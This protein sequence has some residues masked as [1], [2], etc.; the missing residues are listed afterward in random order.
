MRARAGVLLAGLIVVG[1]ATS[2]GTVRRP[3]SVPFFPSPRVHV[4]LC[5]YRQPEVAE[6]RVSHDTRSELPAECTKHY[7]T[8]KYACSLTGGVSEG[9]RQHI[10][11]TGPGNVAVREQ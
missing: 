4:G 9:G 11:C 7:P 8:M 5:T 6:R 10:T 1:C 3:G 2:A